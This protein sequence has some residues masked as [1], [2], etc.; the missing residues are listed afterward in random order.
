MGGLKIARPPARSR[1]AYFCITRARA[2]GSALCS[3]RGL[4]N[5]CDACVYVCV[6]A[7]PE[8]AGERETLTLRA[9]AVSDNEEAAARLASHEFSVFFVFE[10]QWL[11]VAA[12][13]AFGCFL[14]CHFQ[15]II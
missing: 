9:G 4:E 15:G 3:P 14:N 5:G 1:R 2:R 6:C 13:N 7:R 11:V 8:F 10:I 12:I